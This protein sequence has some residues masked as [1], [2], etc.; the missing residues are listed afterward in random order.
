MV[1]FLIFKNVLIHVNLKMVKNCFFYVFWLGR[2]RSRIIFYCSGFTHFLQGFGS[3][4]LSVTELIEL[5]LI[6][7]R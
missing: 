1:Y 4:T 7:I 3:A 6:S 2:G 5:Q